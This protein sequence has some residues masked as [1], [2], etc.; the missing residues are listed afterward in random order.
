MYNLKQCNTYC[1]E[2]LEKSFGGHERHSEL[3]EAK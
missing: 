2:V 3:K 1:S